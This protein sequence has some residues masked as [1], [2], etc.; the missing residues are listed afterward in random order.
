MFVSATSS[1]LLRH[2]YFIISKLALRNF[3]FVIC[4]FLPVSIDDITLTDEEIVAAKRKR[5]ILIVVS[6]CL[7]LFAIAG[8]IAAPRVRNAIRGV[9]ARRHARQAFALIDQ[10]K[11]REARDEATAA[12]QLRPNEPQALRAVA[13]L[14]S[15]AGQA[16]AIGFWKNLAAVSP[17]TRQDRRDEAEVAIRTNDLAT[18][19]DAV[20]HLLQNVD[21]QPGVAD[22]ILAAQVAVRKRQFD[23][24]SGF[25]QKALSDSAATKHDRLRATLTLVDVL[26]GAGENDTNKSR[27][28]GVRLADLTK[29]DDQDSL[30]AAVAL[31]QR[32]L[33]ASED[34]KKS[35]PA[36][37]NDLAN[38]IQNH[39]LAK[40]MQK[41]LAAD[42]EIAANPSQR[43]QIEDRTIASMARCRQRR[44]GRPWRLALP[45]R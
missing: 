22:F 31:S 39:P 13:R 15:R 7:L 34:E 17:L 26:Q 28:L 32:L 40:P 33:N 3:Y 45:A 43:E 9:Q 27:D 2:S 44:V 18:A 25:A 20:E 19:Q 42:L 1:F 30:D 24:A 4:N 16:D 8:V 10:Q 12:Y 36:T 41:L 29:G 38:K 5:R 6:V 37:L 21:G 14:L 35:S 23:K 11:W